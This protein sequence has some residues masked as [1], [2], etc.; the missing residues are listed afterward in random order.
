MSEN[1]KERLLK[2]RMA[3]QNAQNREGVKEFRPRQIG[4]WSVGVHKFHGTPS[5]IIYSLAHLFKKPIWFAVVNVRDIGWE[6]AANAGWDLERTVIVRCDTSLSGEIL[7]LLLESFGVVIAGEIDLA[8]RLERTL[9]AKARK[10][11]RLIFMA[12]PQVHGDI[13]TLQEGIQNVG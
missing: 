1:S 8:P 11:E 12:A 2:A 10:F 13:N 6:A 3:L 9:A 4:G 5:E 7:S